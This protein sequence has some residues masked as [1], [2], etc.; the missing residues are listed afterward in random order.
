M[1]SNYMK[2]IYVKHLILLFGIDTFKVKPV[3]RLTGFQKPD[4]I[5]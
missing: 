3:S 1:T 5:K 4:Y 2:V